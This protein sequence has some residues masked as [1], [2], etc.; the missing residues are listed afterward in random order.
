MQISLSQSLCKISP[1]KCRE[2]SIFLG[3]SSSETL[4]RIME[5]KEYCYKEGNLEAQKHSIT[6]AQCN[7][8]TV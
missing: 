6:K 8:S 2:G 4:L 7:K 1:T 5:E 3:P